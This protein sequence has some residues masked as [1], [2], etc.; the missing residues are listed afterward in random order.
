MCQNNPKKIVD[1]VII[2]YL[3]KIM[4]YNKNKIC[5]QWYFIFWFLL[6]SL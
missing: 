3:R 1:C 6:L 2:S 4:A 5:L